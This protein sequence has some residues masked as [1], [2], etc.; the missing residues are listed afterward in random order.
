MR[1]DTLEEGR[2]TIALEN[3]AEQSLPKKHK[4]STVTNRLEILLH[5]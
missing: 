4:E 5:R 1:L 3:F 2:K